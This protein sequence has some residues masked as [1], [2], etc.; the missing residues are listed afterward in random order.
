MSKIVLG[1]SASIAAYKSADLVSQLV[2]LGHDVHVV[3][4]KHA[5]E[6]ITPLTLQ[7]LSKNPVSIEVMEEADVT[8]INHIDLAQDCDLFVVIPASANMIGKLANGI[9]DDLLSTM[10][11]AVPRDTPKLIVPAMNTVMYEHPAV[12]RNLQQLQED[13]YQIIEPKTSLLACGVTGKGALADL[14]DL[15]DR[16]Q[17]TL[18]EDK[19]A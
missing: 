4:T 1:V 13:G 2:K 16:I 11:L 10:A 17:M 7:V 6:F 12:V 14:G 5:T 18:K 19:H 8:K 15:I 9:A 3:M